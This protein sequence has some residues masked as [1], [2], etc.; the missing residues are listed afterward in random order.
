MLDRAREAGVQGFLVPAVH[1]GEFEELFKLAEVEPGVWLALGVHPHEASSWQSG[2]GCR[3]LGLLKH[4]KVVAVGECGLDRY[5]QHAP[6]P[7]Q[8]RVFREQLEVASEASLPAV[9][10]HRDAPEE[11]VAIVKREEFH[12]LQFDFH[13]F[14]GGLEL[15][16]RLPLERSWFGVS[17]MVT[18]AKAENVREI[19][20]ELGPTRLLVETDT[21]Y[22]APV[23]FRGKQ[24]EP[25]LLTRIVDRLGKELGL[26][27]EQIATQTTANFFNL[28]SRA[29]TGSDAEA[30]SQGYASDS[31]AS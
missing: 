6:I 29:W 7:V 21:P 1:F 28:F 5:Y 23:P 13:S 17:G 18:F 26:T 15:V 31:A 19:L 10:H 16:R 9:V 8:E 24:N 14:T 25:A 12:Q 20:P 3:L 4:P 11:L 22:L 30:A 2:D 27:A